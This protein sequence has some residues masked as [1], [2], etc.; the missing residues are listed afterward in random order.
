MW[1]IRVN[2]ILAISRAFGD[3]Q[4]KNPIPEQ[5]DDWE[6]GLVISRPEVHSELMTPMTE[7]MLLATDGLWDILPPQEAISFVRA[8][9]Q[10]HRDLQQAAKEL[11]KEALTRGSVD[12]VT[13]LIVVFGV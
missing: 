8:K 3:L 11:V 6:D 10:A 2:G 1:N 5:M 13:V 9:L 12:N 7:F 4:F